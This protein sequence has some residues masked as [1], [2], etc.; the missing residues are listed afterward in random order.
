MIDTL[1]FDLGGTLVEYY[2]R[3]QYDTVLGEALAEARVFLDERGLLN[4]SQESMWQRAQEENYEAEDH[5]VRPLGERLR[6][7]FQLDGSIEHEA[8][9]DMCRRFLR[10]VFARGCCYED[11][12]ST[13][14]QLKA[15]GFRMAIV[16]NTPWGAPAA[17][18]REEIERLGPGNHVEAI[19]CCADVGWRK[20][21]MQFFEYTLE[22]LQV[23]PGQC[24]CVGDRLQWDVI[25]ARTSGI[26]A[27]LID[28]R[29]T[30]QDSGENPIRNLHELWDRL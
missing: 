10:P 16:T 21:A 3:S 20:P 9:M 25:G 15:R 5:R 12:I 14:E 8:E 19:V 30:M 4:V 1:L 26:R 2:D 27:L 7:I 13:L 18:W 28:R 24:I 23:S 17:P 11:T 22:K 29:G 6:R